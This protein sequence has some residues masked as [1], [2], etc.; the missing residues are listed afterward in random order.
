M[1]V[2]ERRELILLLEAART[3][4]EQYFADT[5]GVFD[6]SKDYDVLGFPSTVAFLKHQCRMS[7]AR[8]KRSTLLA[9]AARKF[10]ATF[11]SWKHNQISS[12]EAHLLFQM[13]ERM[14]DKY[15]DAEPVLLEIVGDSYDETRRVL[16][17]WRQTVDKPG[18]LVDEQIQMNRRRLDVSRKA[19]GMVEGE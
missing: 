18:I 4:L 1:S 16:D 11:S 15:P 12:D 8:A 6:E 7:G 14:P 3:R 17:Y 9:R 5:L 13:A 19:N 2:D 10:Q